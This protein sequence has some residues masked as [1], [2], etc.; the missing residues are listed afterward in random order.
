[1]EPYVC[2]EDSAAQIY[3]WLQ[4]RGGIL[5]W[6]SLNLSNFE[7]SWTTPAHN[8]DGTPATRPTW[9]SESSPRRT[10]TDPA[11]VV[12]ATSR[13]LKRFHVA[14]R[15]GAQGMSMK[16]TTGGSRRIRAEVEKAT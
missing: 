7:A 16:V 2:S 6:D 14:T 3:S 13:E 1:M 9:Q 10:I 8:A 5:I 11:E 4:G 15:M 12:V